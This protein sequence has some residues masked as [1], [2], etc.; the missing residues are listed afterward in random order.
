MILCFK[1]YVCKKN[2][3]SIYDYLH[4]YTRNKLVQFWDKNFCIE[5][6]VKQGD[7]IS[8]LFYVWVLNMLCD[9]GN[10]D[11]VNVVGALEGIPSNNCAA[12]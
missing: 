6:G 5:R 4:P 1:A 2:P 10:F 9:N 12:H 3:A 7:V 11:H 8:P